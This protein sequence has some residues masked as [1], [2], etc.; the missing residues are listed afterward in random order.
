MKH[1]L[2]L[3][4]AAALLV[5]AISCSTPAEVSLPAI[6]SDHMVLQKDCDANLWGSS[7]PGAKV[8]VKWRGKSYSATA[9]EAGGWKLSVP[10]G[11]AGGPFTLKIGDRTL[12]DVLVGEVFICSGQSNMELQVKR[13]LDVVED[14]IR[15]YSNSSI[16]YFSV[17]TAYDFSG[18]AEDLAGGSWEVLDSEQTALQWSAVCYFT[19]RYINEAAEVPVGMIKTALGGS[20]IE[21]WMQESILPEYALDKLAPLK[22]KAYTDSLKQAAREVYSEWARKY[23]ELPAVGEKWSRIELF[24]RDWALDGKG[25]PWYGGHHFRKTVTLSESQAAGESVLHL[26][27]ITDADSVFVNGKFVGNTTYKYPPRN[28]TVPAGTLK[29]GENLIEIHLF[30]YGDDPASFVRDKQY[31]LETPD[32]EISLMKG[33]EHS[34]GKRMPAR[35]KEIFLQWEPAGLYNSMLAP[36]LSYRSAGVIWYQG[37]SNTGNAAEYGGLLEKMITDWRSGM[38]N[39]E[40]PFYIIELADYQHSELAGS[41]SGWGR[42]QKEQRRTWRGWRE[43]GLSLT[44]TSANGTMYTRRTRRPSGSARQMKY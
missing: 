32:G 14:D 24:S 16:R 35:D 7:A 5:T 3:I 39:P 30:S 12:S 27:A 1:T 21:S 18:P 26:G 8:S 29:A 9:D 25:K 33:W 44:P 10:A 41:D 17:P 43:S 34:Y 23:R 4:A 15:D 13:C 6:F 28:Y 42:L 37:E 11:E 2:K 20:P 38:E 22:D 40:L 36:V 31:S 19:A